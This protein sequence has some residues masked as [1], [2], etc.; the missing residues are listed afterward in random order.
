MPAIRLSL[1]THRR[2]QPRSIWSRNLQAFCGVNADCD[3]RRP[4][5]TA[6]AWKTPLPA[7]DA[8]WASQGMFIGHLL[9]TRNQAIDP[10][11][12]L[13]RCLGLLGL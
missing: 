11:F 1:K 6:E 4:L 3:W 2:G 7:T 12:G 10:I 9:D 8:L 13:V 5:P